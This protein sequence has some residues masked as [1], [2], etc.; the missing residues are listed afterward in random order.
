MQE[1]N[2]SRKDSLEGS[3]DNLTLDTSSE[4]VTPSSVFSCS[5]RELLS[6]F[7]MVIK[8]LK[9][10]LNKICYKNYEKLETQILNIIRDKIVEDKIINSPISTFDDIESVFNAIIEKVN[11]LNSSKIPVY[12]IIPSEEENIIKLYA[13]LCCK[14]YEEWKPTGVSKE[15]VEGEDNII[16]GRDGNFVSKRDEFFKCIDEDFTKKLNENRYEILTNLTDNDQKSKF[17]D[18]FKNFVEFSS[19]LYINELFTSTYI[20][21]LLDNL[22]DSF[23]KQ[24]NVTDIKLISIILKLTS[25]TMSQEIA[26][27]SLSISQSKNEKKNNKLKEKKEKLSKKLG[28]YYNYINVIYEDTDEISIKDPCIELIKFKKDNW[29]VIKVKKVKEENWKDV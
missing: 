3:F 1:N 9:L 21:D 8:E 5:N 24:Q 2:L 22:F 10:T 29:R 13:A 15:E 16:M 20:T 11:K 26:N 7:S 6:P 25:E 27:I 19:F 23:F 28:T 17:S 4:R 18:R 12:V 14:I